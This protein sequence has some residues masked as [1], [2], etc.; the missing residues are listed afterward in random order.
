MENPM[1]A[2]KDVS[3]FNT[4]SATPPWQAEQI[5][6]QAIIMDLVEI[7]FQ[8]IYPIFPFFHQPTTIRKVSRGE[9][10]TSKSQFAVTMAMCALASARA[11]DGAI[12]TNQWD[13]SALSKTSSEAFFAAAESVLPKGP[14]T[15]FNFMRAYA[16]LSIT[17][18]QYGK[19]QT[20]FYYLGLYHTCIE[21]DGLHDEANWSKDAGIV[22]LEERR[23]LFW[24]MYTLDV[25]TSIAWRRVIRSCEAQSNVTYPTPV[26]DA[27]FSDTG[28]KPIAVPTNAMEMAHGISFD[29]KPLCWLHG[30]NATTDLYRIL[31]H[32]VAQFRQR[33]PEHR[34]STSIDAIFAA[35]STSS[36]LVLDVVFNMYKG[37]PSRLKETPVARSEAEHRLN[38]Q[39]ANLAATIQLV[40][41][42]LFAAEDA[43]VEQRCRVASEL[44]QAFT[45]V[46]II[47]LRAISSPLLHHLASIGSILGS[48][49]E[50]GLPESSY[51]KIR[52]VLLSMIKLLADL[53]VGLS[54]TAG[55]STR[56]QAL[57]DRIDGF[58][59]SRQ[60]D[61]Y[62]SQSHH[63][64]SADPCPARPSAT[65]P[66]LT[67]GSPLFL[68]PTELL[69]D[70]SWA[71]DFGQTSD[72]RENGRDNDTTVPSS[73]QCPTVS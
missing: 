63:D 22:A 40:R 37:L 26:D 54:C 12:I 43:T 24:S 16:L 66:Y 39:T 50:G 7:Y 10:Q 8:I 57:V 56:I 65:P 30:W 32:V 53:E 18:I 71:F 62:T 38:F 28:Y 2:T 6:S 67:G 59:S 29:N 11:R 23:R 4:P 72:T 36:A 45:D 20:M 17:A 35:Q 48:T 3:S 34:T 25:Y 61:M 5:A 27:D 68:L 70:W 19:P 47:Y 44:L 21:I 1:T 51:R 46:P 73:I 69:D 64:N 13:L 52:S 33:R 55:A 58:I 15:D 60:Q 41:I 49:F 14:V 9:H 42:M 31:E